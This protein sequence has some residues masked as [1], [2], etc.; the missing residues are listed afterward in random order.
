MP[1]E[2]KIQQNVVLAPFTTFKIGGPAKFFVEVKSKEELSGAIGWARE[3]KENFF[4]L[5]GGSNVLIN[6]NGVRGL[7]VKISNNDLKVKGE[8]I[9]CG[10][11][12]R[13]AAA[14]SL[15]IGQNLTG[16]EWSIG[17]PGATVGGAVVGNAGAFA[18]AMSDIVETVEAF[19]AEKKKFEILS[20]RDCEFGYRDSVFKKKKG[21][22]LWSVVLRLKK[23]KPEIIRELVKQ[24]VDFRQN[25]YPKLPSAGSVFKN[26]PLEKIKE[27]NPVLAKEIS[28]RGAV[29]G[30]LV[31]AGA[32]I[33]M[34]GLKGKAI[35]GAKISLEHA[36]HIVN[37]GKA[38]AGD[39]VMLISYIKQQARDKFG[40]Q[41]N[42]EVRYL[43]F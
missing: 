42:E 33:D 35:G 2:Q 9:E 38:A 32:I 37:T 23:E 28:E 18:A 21:L 36:N 4:V 10:A 24:S 43:G 6:D 14:A 11:G 20:N 39:V 8:R 41:L 13:L 5:A 19:N 26:I 27:K 40:I 31:G 3:N 25:K 17:I 16:L 12:A 34:L 22:I 29:S 15:A 7:V 30:G 1:I